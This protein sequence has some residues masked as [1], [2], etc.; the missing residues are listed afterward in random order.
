M[1]IQ[2]RTSI[3]GKIELTAPTSWVM[4]TDQDQRL[5]GRREGR[6]WLGTAW[7]NWKRAG[8]GIPVPKQRPRVEAAGVHV[9]VTRLRVAIAGGQGSG[10]G[11]GGLVGNFFFFLNSGLV[12]IRDLGACMDLSRPRVAFPGPASAGLTGP[13]IYGNL[14]FLLL[15]LPQMVILSLFLS[16]AILPPLY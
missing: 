6:T 12:G 15:F 8:G 10:G 14:T 2:A 11:G 16:C 9:L 13:K 7:R 4:E 3:W 5:C 1:S